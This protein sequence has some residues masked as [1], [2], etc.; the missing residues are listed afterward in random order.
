MRHR[1]N[2]P[3]VQKRVGPDVWIRDQSRQFFGWVVFWQLVFGVTPAVLVSA[4]FW[5]H[6]QPFWR[7]AVLAAVG[8][9]ILAASLVRAFRILTAGL[10]IADDELI[11]RGIYRTRRIPVGDVC[12]FEEWS[13]SW[14]RLS[15]QSVRIRLRSRGKVRV[16]AF[17]SPP[18]I[19]SA[20]LRWTEVVTELNAVVAAP[21]NGDPSR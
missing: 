21:D 8:G 3:R 2:Q 12:R 9:A 6:N 14:G 11:V 19:G 5:A 7:L 15:T 13:Y 18:Y 20:P 17:Q 4:P 1:A 16:T 10:L